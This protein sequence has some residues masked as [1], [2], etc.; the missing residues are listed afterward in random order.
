MRLT[1]AKDSEDKIR[2]QTQAMSNDYE[3]IDKDESV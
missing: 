3:I 1:N 2:K